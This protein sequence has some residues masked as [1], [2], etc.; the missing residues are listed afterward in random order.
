[1]RRWSPALLCLLCASACRQGVARPPLRLEAEHTAPL[2]SRVH[3]NL[4]GAASAPPAAPLSQA[5]VRA[6]PASPSSC[7]APTPTADWDTALGAQPT[8][9]S[10]GQNRYSMSAVFLAVTGAAPPPREGGPGALPLRL[11]LSGP[12]SVGLR[13]PLRLRL[14]AHN[15]SPRSWTVLRANDGSFE[16]RR[17]PFVDLYAEDLGSH[18]V[19]RYT[20]VGGRCGF[21]NGLAPSDLLSV[22][23]GSA[24]AEPFA[25][26]ASHLGEAHFLQRGRYRVWVVYAL[27]SYAEA[28]GMAPSP[29]PA[30]RDLFL[31]RV[32]SN[33]VE[34]TVR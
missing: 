3:S 25:R 23:P 4:Q 7:A 9:D 16:Q 34:L 30:P 11:E 12:A 19:Y 27:C 20:G 33:A 31:G 1:M 18:R 22:P 14:T 17:E 10:A 6:A 26:W 2:A 15:Q 13:E 32:A 21:I 28:R 8:Q 24:T 29:P 5:E